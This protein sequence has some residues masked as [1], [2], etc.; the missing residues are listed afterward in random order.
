MLEGF[1]SITGL[2]SVVDDDKSNVMF[3]DFVRVV[4]TI[5]FDLLFTKASSF[6]SSLFEDVSMYDLV[7]V[8]PEFVVQAPVN[9]IVV[10]GIC[11]VFNIGLNILTLI[12]LIDDTTASA[13]DVPPTTVPLIVLLVGKNLN[14]L[15]AAD[16]E[17]KYSVLF[18]ES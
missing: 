5:S 10:P 15:L 3:R 4:P 1:I 8:K 17:F 12:L 16:E 13:C 18:A 2:I 9:E 11:K 6:K 14:A 7:L